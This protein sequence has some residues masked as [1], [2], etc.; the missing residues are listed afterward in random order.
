MCTKNEVSKHDQMLIIELHAIHVYY[1]VPHKP[2]VSYNSLSPDNDKDFLSGVS[3]PT[4]GEIMAAT[5]ALCEQSLERVERNS[6]G[7]HGNFTEQNVYD[8]M[9]HDDC[10]TN[11]ALRSK[12][13]NASGCNCLEL[14]TVEGDSMFKT[15]GDWCRESSGAKLCKVMGQCGEWQCAIDDFHCKRM[16]YNTIFVPL[17]GYGQKCSLA[18]PLAVHQGAFTLALVLCAFLYSN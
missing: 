17:K 3:Y 6:A 4:N 8:T 1:T 5:A 7:F 15:E 11:D 18:L 16:E 12:A 14:S 13:M 2:T 9:C 10:I